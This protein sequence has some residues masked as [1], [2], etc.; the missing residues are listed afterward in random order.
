MTVCDFYIYG[1][2]DGTG[3][4]LLAVVEETEQCIILTG[5][6]PDD[7]PNHPGEEFD[8]ESDAYHLREW[9]EENGMR[10]FKCGYMFN[11]IGPPFKVYE[12]EAD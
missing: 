8:F 2:V 5:V 7:H 10:T 11:Q 9:A 4:H 12:N 1:V 3:E 6:F